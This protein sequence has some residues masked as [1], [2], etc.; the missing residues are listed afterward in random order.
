MLIWRMWRFFFNFLMTI[1]DCSLLNVEV[2]Y[3]KLT[4]MALVE[5]I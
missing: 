2:S 1:E 3:V 5:L 4:V